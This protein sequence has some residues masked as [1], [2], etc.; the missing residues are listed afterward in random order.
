MWQVSREV[1][2][3][4][5]RHLLIYR[6]FFT[7]VHLTP[8]GNSANGEVV[9]PGNENCQTTVS[10]PPPASSVQLSRATTRAIAN[11]TCLVLGNIHNIHNSIFADIVRNV[12]FLGKQS[13][14]Q[15]INAPCHAPGNMGYR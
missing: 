14:K 4:L 7:D 2:V 10:Q 6:F 3:T 13:S 9:F 12:L 5:M 15:T 1:S 8:L 11:S